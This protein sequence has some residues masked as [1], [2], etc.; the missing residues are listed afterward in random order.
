MTSLCMASDSTTS[1]VTNFPGTCL[2]A[3]LIA[4]LVGEPLI[5]FVLSLEW[6]RRRRSSK[7]L[8]KR[9]RVVRTLSFVNAEVK[10]LWVR[11][12]CLNQFPLWQGLLRQKLYFLQQP[13]R[14]QILYSNGVLDCSKHSLR[15]GGMLDSC[16]ISKR[17]HGRTDHLKGGRGGGNTKGYLL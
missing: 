8:S 14:Q 3:L 1:T 2:L 10:P 5:M 4:H 7:S 12:S 11:A 9:V 13:R 17:L 15:Q 16:Q 6:K